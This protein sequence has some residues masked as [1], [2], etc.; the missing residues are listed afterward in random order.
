MTGSNQTKFLRMSSTRGRAKTFGRQMS[1][2]PPYVSRVGAAPRTKEI[3][4]ART[5]PVCENKRSMDKCTRV[6]RFSSRNS[7]AV[8]QLLGADP[9]CWEAGGASVAK[10][11]GDPQA[12]KE[13]QDEG[14]ARFSSQDFPTRCRLLQHGKHRGRQ[15]RVHMNLKMFV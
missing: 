6:Y 3:A 12:H 1:G 7:K 9:H 11:H 5:R 14:R 2:P 8:Q 15:R 10:S 4:A 13:E